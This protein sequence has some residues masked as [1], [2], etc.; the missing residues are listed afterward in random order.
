[1]QLINNHT[2]YGPVNV[3]TIPETPH[4]NPIEMLCGERSDA[5]F[6]FNTL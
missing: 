3:Y 6:V 2:P 5:C 1:M 4:S